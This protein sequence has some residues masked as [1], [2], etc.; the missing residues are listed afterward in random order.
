MKKKRQLPKLVAY[1][2]RWATVNDLGQIVKLGKDNAFKVSKNIR[3]YEPDELM[4]WL[5]GDKDILRV[6]E[7]NRGRKVI[8]F[9]YCKL[10]S[11][12]WAY[13]DNFYIVPGYRR[14]GLGRQMLSDLAHQLEGNGIKYLSTLVALHEFDIARWMTQIG[15]FASKR[16]YVWLEKFL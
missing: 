9:Y 14:K 2:C 12:H 16:A 3:F 13:L 6:L 10:M 8:G 7:L 15:G 5:V 4:D 1:T 11:R